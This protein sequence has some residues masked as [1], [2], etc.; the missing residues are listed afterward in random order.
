M[1]K[2]IMV[3]CG[4]PRENGNT[5]NI[6]KWFRESACEAGAEVEIIDAAKLKY[7][8]YGCIACMGCQHSDKYECV[9]EDEATPI[10]ARIPD[11]D[12]LVLATPVYFFGPSAQIK[13]FGDRMFS[14]FKFVPEKEI[15]LHNLEGKTLALIASGGSD[16]SS[17]LSNI[18]SIC[19]TM[20]KFTCMDYKS[21]LIPFAP[22]EEGA[23]TDKTDIKEKAINFG[24]E[25]SAG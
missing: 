9:I 1:A 17:G 18:E 7:K 25:L 12:V 24:K 19:K 6:V 8:N 14:L 22:R 4:S 10:L 13:V 3:I 15:F 23:I 5:S 2:K 16:M 20:A 21:L 11:M